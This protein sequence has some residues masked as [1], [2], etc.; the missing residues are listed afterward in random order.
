MNNVVYV[1]KNDKLAQVW[2]IDEFISEWKEDDFISGNFI[3]NGNKGI[4]ALPENLHVKGDLKL[5]GLEALERLGRNIR[6]DG[7]IIIENC[8][9]LEVIDDLISLKNIKIFN[10]INLSTIGS[11]NLSTQ[12]KAT[13]DIVISLCP[14]LISVAGSIES[15]SFEIN[16]CERLRELEASIV[17]LDSLYLVNTHIEKISSSVLLCNQASFAGSHSLKELPKKALINTSFIANTGKTHP[18]HKIHIMS[19]SKVLGCKCYLTQGNS[20][21]KIVGVLSVIAGIAGVYWFK[22][23]SPK[24]LK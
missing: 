21:L 19:C 8:P 12:L 17:L 5:I 14:N 13:D 9:K 4:K 23:A 22:G 10:C 15:S 2:S 3:L 1:S 6:V 18:G 20:V 7:D 11:S 16:R 24:L